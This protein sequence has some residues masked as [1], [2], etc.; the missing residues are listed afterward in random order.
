KQDESKDGEHHLTKIGQVLGSPKYMSP[1]QG[2]GRH[3]DGRTD[4]YSIGA[5][6]Y[7]MLV[8][9]PPFEKPNAMATLMAH[10]SEPVPLMGTIAPAVV[11]PV[12]LEPVVRKCLEKEPDA[13]FAS[14]DELLAALREHAGP[15]SALTTSGQTLSVSQGA[16][17]LDAQPAPPRNRRGALLGVF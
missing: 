11:L 2:Q 16:A 8:G 17:N 7:A 3:I 12:G 13:R 10:V 5:T 9:R 15:N 1:E 6:L 4:I 14:M